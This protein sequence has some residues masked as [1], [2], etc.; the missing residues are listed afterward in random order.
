MGW[1][2]IRQGA[3]GEN[4]A[5]NMINVRVETLTQRSAFR[6][7]LAEPHLHGS[8]RVRTVFIVVAAPFGVAAFICQIL[9]TS[10]FTRGQ[11]RR[12]PF[13]T[14]LDGKQVYLIGATIIFG[15]LAYGS[16]MVKD[17]FS[18][19]PTAVSVPGPQG[20]SRQKATLTGFEKELAD[21]AT[22][23]ASEAKHYFKAAE[24]D[25]EAR[26]YRDAAKN[27]QKSIGH[28]PR[29]RLT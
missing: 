27:D 25:F 7:L 15:I 26:R 6:S 9:R 19:T 18:I 22:E 21:A 10:R 17:F 28:L 12:Y 23:H 5:Y 11:R 24:H 2:L 3:K 4:T 13:L 1:G 29:A 20:E 16:S 14:K 8:H